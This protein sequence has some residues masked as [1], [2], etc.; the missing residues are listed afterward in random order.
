[1]SERFL[2]Y[3]I[4]IRNI[5]FMLRCL[6]KYGCIYTNVAFCT[7][8]VWNCFQT[9]F[10]FCLKIS[11]HTL[12]KATQFFCTVATNSD[13]L[14]IKVIILLI[15][16]TKISFFTIYISFNMVFFLQI[17]LKYIKK[18]KILAIDIAESRNRGMWSISYVT[19]I[20]IIA[21]VSLTPLSMFLFLDVP[22]LKLRITVL[23]RRPTNPK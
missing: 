16:Y 12:A 2:S 15:S 18:K 20:D 6:R 8:F 21:Q 11:S 23:L 4:C 14:Q 13:F 22:T 19:C 1:M 3:V 17:T 10:W 7:R 5:I 9:K